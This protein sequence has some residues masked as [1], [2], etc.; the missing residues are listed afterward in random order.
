MFRMYASNSHTY[1]HLILALGIVRKPTVWDFITSQY[2]G[3]IVMTLACLVFGFYMQ[4]EL[5]SSRVY[6]LAIIIFIV[7]IKGPRVRGSAPP[8]PDVM[9]GGTVCWS[10]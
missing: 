4:N 3:Y 1:T 7:E 5:V 8:D 9:Y 6:R 2:P 10:R